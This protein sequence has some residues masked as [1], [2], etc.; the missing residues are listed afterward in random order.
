MDVPNY[1][2]T[3]ARKTWQAW[4]DWSLPYHLYH[5]TPGALCSILVQYGF[6]VVRTKNY[7][8]EYVKQ[9]V[10]RIPGLK[11]VAGLIAS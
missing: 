6:K 7:H 1:E 3:D 8:S 9:R 10:G 5:F 2:G 4:R 11:P